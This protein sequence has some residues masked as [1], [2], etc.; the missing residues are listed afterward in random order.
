MVADKK[1]TVDSEQNVIGRAASRYLGAAFQFDGR[2]AAAAMLE[3]CQIVAKEVR[4]E[5]HRPGS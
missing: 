4:Q 1:A 5:T 2:I 3:V